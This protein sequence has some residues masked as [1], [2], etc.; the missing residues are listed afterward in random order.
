[1]SHIFPS[2]SQ[3]KA[4]DFC[5]RSDN[6]S[7]NQDNFTSG[8]D[9]E[10]MAW[11][12]GEI[13]K[14]V[15]EGNQI[16][17]PCVISS[18]AHLKSPLSSHRLLPPFHNSSSYPWNESNLTISLNH[19]LLLL[20]RLTASE[21]E[22]LLA[23]IDENL[24]TVA[25]EIATAK[26]EEKP[27]KIEKLEEK[28][29]AIQL[30]KATVQKIQAIQHR[31]KHGDEILKLRVKVIPLMALEDKGRSMSLTLADLKSIEEKS[32]IETDIVLLENAS[33][34]WFEEEADFVLKCKIEEKEAKARYAAKVKAQAGKGGGQK[35]SSSGASKSSSTQRSSSS[36]SSVGPGGWSSIGVK[37]ATPAGSS[38]AKKAASS[39]FAAAFGDEDSD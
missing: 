17:A 2:T 23:S 22:E 37:K 6:R 10:K 13:K 28:Q 32:D 26:A 7:T 29:K 5:D 35:S 25:E 27:K 20:G 38:G 1:V 14:F 18:F 21:K 3:Y 34:G 33:R 36:S 19:C 39:G 16:L 4:D 31:L 30:R 24:I 12:Q 9:A 15:D 11:L 8:V